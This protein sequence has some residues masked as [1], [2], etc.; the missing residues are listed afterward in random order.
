MIQR[1]FLLAAICLSA[2]VYSGEA[3]AQSSK[4]RIY[5]FEDQQLRIEAELQ[6]VTKAG[7]VFSATLTP[8]TGWKIL[9]GNSS[10][11]KPLK[12]VFKPGKCLKTRGATRF[13]EPDWSGTDD[14]GAY[15]EYYTKSAGLSQEFSRIS[16]KGGNEA[17][18]T[19]T[20]L[21]CQDNKCVGPLHKDI[22][23]KV[24]K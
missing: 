7:L 24:P 21:L 20:Y 3:S 22:T 1:N 6:P 12:A 16:C 14:S 19:I 5:S 4:E 13:T 23:F 9:A 2:A 17:A 8:K 10:G 15:S 11:I 18:A